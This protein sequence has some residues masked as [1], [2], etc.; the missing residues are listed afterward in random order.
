[1]SGT[2]LEHVGYVDLPPHKGKGGFDHAAVHAASGHVFVAHTANDAVDVFDPMR[3]AY[4][5]SIPDLPGVA[6]ALV[7]DEG[8]LILS[9]NRGADTIGIFA[10]GQDP[11]VR[12]LGVGVRPNGLAYDH[13][14]QLVLAANVGDEEVPGTHTVS[15]VW[16]GGDSVRRE[17]A[18][19]GRTRWSLFDPTTELFYVNIA[20]PSQIV[21]IDARQADRIARTFAIAHA[22]AHGLDLDIATQRLFCACDAAVLVT[23]DARSG[24]VLDQKPLS[25][26]PDVVWFNRQRQQLYVAVGDPGVIDV[27]STSTMEKLA[28]I[29]TEPGAHTTALSPNG[30]WLCAFLPHSHRAA[31]Y[32]IDG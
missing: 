22:G 26:V 13:R 8:Q 12:R 4:L 23:L 20:K 24:G 1:M 19:P 27:F 14:R 21:V 16:L 30:D 32:R 7:S 18:V 9:S 6:G 25:G 5:Y 3:R 2:P 10:P 15:M 29:A 17:I 28:T 31:V 11:T